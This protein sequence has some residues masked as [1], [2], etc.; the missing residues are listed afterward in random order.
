M[1]ANGDKWRDVSSVIDKENC[2]MMPECLKN[3]HILLFWLLLPICYNRTLVCRCENSALALTEFCTD[4]SLLMSTALRLRQLLTN[5]KF[6][7]LVC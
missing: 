2:K 1:I 3:L 7:C 6:L 5:L 4:C